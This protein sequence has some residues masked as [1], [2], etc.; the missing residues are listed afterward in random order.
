MH[1]QNRFNPYAKRPNQSGLTFSS[2]SSAWCRV[3]SADFLFFALLFL[4]QKSALATRRRRARTR[5]G[6]PASIANT[7]WSR[8]LQTRTGTGLALLVLAD[9]V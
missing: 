6:A 2:E 5:P 1:G 7:T 8:R 9:R 4:C 3:A